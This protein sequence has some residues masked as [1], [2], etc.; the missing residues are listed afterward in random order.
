MRQALP[1]L[2]LRFIWVGDGI[3][4]K[5]AATVPGLTFVGPSDNP[6]AHIERFTVA[7]LPSRDDPFPLVVMEAMLLGKPIVAFAVG[8][9]P[10]QISQAG[11]LVEP[12]DVKQFAEGIVQVLSNDDL[13]SKLGK[14]AQTRAQSEFS[15]AGFSTRLAQIVEGA[16][17]ATAAAPG[18]SAKIRSEAH[19]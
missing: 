13:R 14:H 15:L 4:P 6:Y 1:Q 7:T 16:L 10:S 5:E 8:S 9:V 19:T 12:N 2:P 3:P 11:I 17:I 18:S